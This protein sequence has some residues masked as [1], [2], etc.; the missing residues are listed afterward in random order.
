VPQIPYFRNVVKKLATSLLIFLLFFNWYGYRLLIAYW[1]GAAEQRLLARLDGED[2]D[3]ASL[4]SIKFP[5]A[6]LSYSNASTTFERI[7][8][9]IILGDAAYKYVKRRIINDSI[10]LLCIRNAEVM[11]LREARDDFFQKINDFFHFPHSGN[12]GGRNDIQKIYSPVALLFRLA[13]APAPVAKP[14][15]RELVLSLP[16]GHSRLPGQPP[17]VRGC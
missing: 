17:D 16:P 7:D 12:N 6:G 4:I 5:A 13:A 14:A 3:E 8:G 10:E 1:Q 2:Y 11:R 9:E 15:P